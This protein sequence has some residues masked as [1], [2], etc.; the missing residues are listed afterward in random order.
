MPHSEL[1]ERRKS[2]NIAVLAG[3]FGFVA[4]VFVITIL[5][6]TAGS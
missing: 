5:K 3:V 1:H 4:I 2:K 6:L